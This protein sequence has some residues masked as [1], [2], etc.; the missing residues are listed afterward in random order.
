MD[1]NQNPFPGTQTNGNKS[2]VSFIG[3]VVLVIVL[4]AAGWYL[5]RGREAG[6][7]PSSETVGATGAEEV[8]AEP[9]AATEALSS[10]GTSDEVSAINADL[11]AT[12]LNSLDEINSL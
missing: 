7:I 8:A 4:V 9:D 5:L 12:D 6:G 3:A 1:Q 10:Q 11:N 2:T